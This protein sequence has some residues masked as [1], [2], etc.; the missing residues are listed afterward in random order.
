MSKKESK[1]IRME[2]LLSAAMEEFMEKGYDGASIDA[3]A[4]KAGV[5]KGGFYYHFENKDA[6]LMETNKKICEPIT[7]MA[8]KALINSDP[9]KGL[10]EYIIEYLNYWIKRPKEL[11]FLYLSMSKALESPILM[12]YYKQNVKESTAFF[13]TMFRKIQEEGKVLCQDPEVTGISLMG[14]LDG[15]V[16]YAMVHPDIEANALA[17]RMDK[18]WFHKII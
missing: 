5:S 2:T 12:D 14:A 1:E 6:I 16:S 15:I 13:V 7:E 18:I 4:A 11:S 8:E 17:A 3:I 10:K 9:V